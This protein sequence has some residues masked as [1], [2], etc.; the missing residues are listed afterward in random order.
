MGR[1]FFP[2]LKEERAKTRIL[3]VGCGS[4]ANLWMIAREGFTAA[5]I[6]LSSAAIE[7]CAEMLRRYQVSAELQVG[8]MLKLPWPDGHFAAIA[9]VF[10]SYCLATEDFLHFLAEAYRVLEPRGRLFVYT[11]SKASD[12]WKNPGPSKRID[13]NT[14]DGIRRTDSPFSGN[15]YPHRFTTPDQFRTQAQQAGFAIEYCETVGRTYRNGEEY[16]EFVVAEAVKTDKGKS[17]D[18]LSI[19]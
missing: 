11:S 10:S 18:F 16:F 15:L 8:S 19:V 4:G 12:A 2:K 14:L 5:G 7:L 9:D 1:R 6:D 13:A 17:V 3:E